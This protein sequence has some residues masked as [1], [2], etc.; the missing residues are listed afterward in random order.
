MS[1]SQKSSGENRATGGTA[2]SEL[3]EAQSVLKSDF[4]QSKEGPDTGNTI[5]ERAEQEGKNVSTDTGNMN[6]S[7]NDV[8]D[9]ANQSRKEFAKKAKRDI[10]DL[11]EFIA[12]AYSRKGQRL[13]LK[14]K[15][16]KAVCDSLR[17]EG[18]TRSRL[19]ELAKEDVLLAVPRQILLAVRNITGYPVLKSEV[20]GFVKEVLI[21]HPV[22]SIP[23]IEGAL[24]NLDHGPDPGTALAALAEV[25][26][27]KL[28]DLV[29]K[30]PLK[31]KDYEMLRVNATYSLAV[32]FT[33]TR[34]LS[35]EKLN[36]YLFAAL[37]QPQ[38]LISKDETARLQTLTDICDLPGVGLACLGFKQQA[39]QQMQ[40]VASAKRAEESAIE[41]L[42]SLKSSYEEL[43]R[44]IGEQDREI[45]SLREA[46]QIEK[47]NHEHTRTHMNDDLEHLRSRFLRRLKAEVSLLD[48]GLHA[49]RRDP[50]KIR[51]MEDHAER[52]LDSLKK[53]IKELGSDE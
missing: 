42:R 14:P 11:A 2:Q 16:E 45:S 34:N 38:A 28:T 1:D 13:S 18:E 43:Q 40:I 35:L 49:L 21:R 17:L 48:E 24:N 51:V 19:L 10:K 29:R 37:W 36:Q 6:K 46:L 53:G 33:E 31:P 32:W 4:T 9:N 30:K 8:T 20:W 47:Q 3:A 39:D 50:P 41:H 26:Y 27:S 7:G 44:K 23:E 12:Y 25:D 22:F 15:V 5:D 52:V